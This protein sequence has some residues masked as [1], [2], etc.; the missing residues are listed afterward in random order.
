[1]RAVEAYHGVLS[2]ELPNP[3]FKGRGEGKKEEKE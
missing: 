2:L 1:M 3:S